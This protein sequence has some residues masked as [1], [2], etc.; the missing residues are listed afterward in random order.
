MFNQQNPHSIPEIKHHKI[1]TFWNTLYIKTR[2]TTKQYIT[3]S[4]TNPLKDNKQFL[5]R[6]NNTIHI[7]YHKVVSSKTPVTWKAESFKVPS[8]EQRERRGITEFLSMKRCRQGKRSEKRAPRN[9][10]CCNNTFWHLHTED[11]EC[12]WDA[13]RRGSRRLDPSGIDFIMLTKAYSFQLTV[14]SHRWSIFLF[15][16]FPAAKYSE[17]AEDSNG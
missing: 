9:R 5:Q 12:L 4:K 17:S 15:L 14:Y 16:L 8:N 6:R 2:I 3:P 10:T 7:G 13:R 1:D 11:S